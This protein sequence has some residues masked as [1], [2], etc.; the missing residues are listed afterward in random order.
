MSGAP[1]DVLGARNDAR[2]GA[3]W[4]AS[5]TMA[6][7]VKI[8]AANA[9]RRWWCCIAPPRSHSR[10]VLRV[11]VKYWRKETPM[12]VRVALVGGVTAA[13]AAMAVVSLQ[14]QSTPAR[15]A[16]KPAAAAK[17]YAAKTPWGDPDLQGVWDYKT[18]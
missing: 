5:R 12:N 8:A 3:A 2:F 18:I 10:P 7:A 11:D 4:P 13:I 6:A 16:A 9:V 17:A 15:P 14:A 1:Q